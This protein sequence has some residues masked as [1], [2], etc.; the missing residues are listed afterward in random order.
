MSLHIFKRGINK[1]AIF[2]DTADYEF[3]LG[4]IVALGASHGLD[5]H[6]YA[7]MTNHYHL[8]GTPSTKDVL[9]RV[10]RD[11]S[12]AYVRYFNR[13]YG[14]IGTL[15]NERYGAVLLDDER[16]WLT[17]LRYVEL[18]PVR[19]HLVD[20]SGAYRWSSYRIHAQGDACSWLTTHPT[21]LGLGHDPQ[22]RQSA[23]RS[24]CGVPLTEAELTL[25]RRPPHRASRDPV[26]G[27]GA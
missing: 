10:M 13:K 1:R 18:N 7:L 26:S 9:P 2:A 11:I 4:T 20:D 12:C 16:Y 15:W 17:C 6:A 8:I 27:T 24:I 5:I 23:Y 22:T 25:Q 21:Y 3:L 14:R 19:A